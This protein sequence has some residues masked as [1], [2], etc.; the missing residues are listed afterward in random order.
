DAANWAVVVDGAAAEDVRE[1]PGRHGVARERGRGDRERA[2]VVDPPASLEH[3][4]VYGVV[5]D[6]ALGD[7]QAGAGGVV[8]AAARAREELVPGLVGP[9]GHTIQGQTAIVVDAAALHVRAAGDRQ[10]GD[11]GR[12]PG[13]DVED[14]RRLLAVQG[15]RVGPRPLDGQVLGDVERAAQK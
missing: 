12:H 6:R 14:L 3:V 2:G 4:D 7:R 11:A 10:P 8:D 9:D 13:R 15:Q 5:Q 1:A